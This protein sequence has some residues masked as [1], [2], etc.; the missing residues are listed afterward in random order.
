MP[1]QRHNQITRRKNL[2]VYMCFIF[3]FSR[4]NGR[5]LIKNISGWTPLMYACYSDHEKIVELLISWGVDRYDCNNAGE[6]PLM[7]AALNGNEKMLGLVYKVTYIF[8]SM[9]C[10]KTLIK[11]FPVSQNL[12]CNR[13]CSVQI[14]VYQCCCIIL[15]KCH[16]RPS[17]SG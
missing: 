13:T 3:F 12:V 7:L 4:D 9:L 10:S 16:P 5:L 15:F 6:T 17:Y 11:Q 2:K 14:C 1:I 8:S